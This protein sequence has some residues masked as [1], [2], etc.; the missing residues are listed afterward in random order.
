LGS[1]RKVD[2]SIAS[3]VVYLSI[4]DDENTNN[5]NSDDQEDDTIADVTGTDDEI[6]DGGTE[7]AL[8]PETDIPEENLNP[9]GSDVNIPSPD[10]M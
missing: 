2:S 6:V 10:N 1:H 8:Q 3:L 5:I 4:M 7:S 9:S